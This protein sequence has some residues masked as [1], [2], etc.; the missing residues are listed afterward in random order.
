MPGLKKRLKN[1]Y[2]FASSGHAHQSGRRPKPAVP[3][4]IV[5]ISTSG[6]NWVDLFPRTHFLD[7]PVNFFKASAECPYSRRARY[8]T[9]LRRQPWYP[10]NRFFARFFVIHKT[11][12][13]IPPYTFGE[14]NVEL[15]R[16]R[17]QPTCP[18]YPAKSLPPLCPNIAALPSTDGCTGDVH[19]SSRVRHIVTPPSNHDDG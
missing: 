17:R 5:Q 10:Q 14:N 4:D 15:I 9:V 11:Q 8:P 18:R 7:Y 3:Y 1:P 12:R 6:S 13:S 19:G 16:S 2:I